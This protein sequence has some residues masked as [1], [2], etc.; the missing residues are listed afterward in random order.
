MLKR[1]MLST[2]LALAMSQAA[3]AAG[4]G[5]AVGVDP[6]AVARLSADRVLHVG[7]DVSV[8]E[9]II[10]GKSGQVQ[11]LF[12]DSTRLVVGPGSS[13]LIETYLMASSSTA[14]KIAI[15]ALG[16][17]FR[18]ITGNSPKSAYSI[19]TPTASIAVRGTEFDLVVTPKTT[20]V[21]LYEGALTLCNT[22]GECQ[23]LDSRCEVGLASRADALLYLRA[24]PDRIPL[25][26][27]FRYARFQTGLLRDFRVSGATNCT[28]QRSTEATPLSTTSGSDAE[29]EPSRTQPQT[30]SPGLT[31]TPRQ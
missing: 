22:A 14:Q 9:R 19:D 8:G 27:Q 5:T 4:E 21:M 29:P 20:G 1:L 17:S 12:D 11:I 6:D 15:D 24:D 28:E 10:T 18:F 7:E 13:L 25:S 31:L 3:L 16:G 23:E 26:L 30:Q 2:L